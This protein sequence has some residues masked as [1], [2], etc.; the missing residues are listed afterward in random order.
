M[1]LTMNSTS[2][3][4]SRQSIGTTVFGGMLAFGFLGLFVAQGM[5]ALP[6]HM[7]AVPVN[8][9]ILILFGTLVEFAARGAWTVLS[10]LRRP[11]W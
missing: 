9:F 2:G 1:S 6:S 5:V 3:A 7:Y 11:T 10:K 4:A 8:A